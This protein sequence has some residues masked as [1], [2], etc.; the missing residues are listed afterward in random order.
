MRK[1]QDAQIEGKKVILR[2]DFNVAVEDGRVKEKF[3]ITTVKETLDYLME[4]KSK[5]ALLTYLGRPKGKK[6]LKFSLEKIRD[7]IEN[8]LGYTIKFVPDCIGEEVKKATDDLKDGEVALLENVRFYKGEGDEKSEGYDEE[9]AKKLSIGF[10]LFVNDAFSQSHR[11]QASI[12]GV[13]KYI[14]SCAGLLLQ[15]EISQMEKIKNDFVRPAVAIIGGAKIETKLP[16]IK[17]FEEKYDYVLVGGKIANEALDEK[18]EFSE[19]VILPTDF[20][21]DRLDIGK[22][23]VEKFKEII[24]VSKTILWNGPLGKFEDEKYSMGTYEILDEILVTKKAKDAYVVIGG[25]E[26]LEA[27]ENKNAIN[28]VDFVSTGG[29]AML[30]YLGGKKMPGVEALKSD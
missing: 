30:E 9:F 1:L 17:F 22:N 10:D 27:L 23:T 7:D 26:T 8:V 16:V 3:K 2:V 13:P 20:V 5:V 12:A 4:K 21:D 14:P 6:D 15:K 28:K 25:G 24:S 18:K 19:K 11:N 29:G